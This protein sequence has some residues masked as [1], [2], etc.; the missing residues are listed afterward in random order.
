MEGNSGNGRDYGIDQIAGL[1]KVGSEYIFVR[2]DGSNNWENVLVVAHNSRHDTSLRPTL[3][4]AFYRR[5]PEVPRETLMCA[6]N[7][8]EIYSK[9]FPSGRLHIFVRWG[10][11]NQFSTMCK[12]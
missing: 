4:E 3:I 5:S 12:L 11:D 10:K 6:H 7:V 2:G 1:S 8:G 9:Y